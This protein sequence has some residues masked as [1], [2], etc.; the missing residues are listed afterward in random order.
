MGQCLPR[1]MRRPRSARQ[2]E[3]LAGDHKQKREQEPAGRRSLPLPTPIDCAQAPESLTPVG[4]WV[5]VEAQSVGSHHS[6]ILPASGLVWS[7][8]DDV[9]RKPLP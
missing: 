3:Y 9:K 8:W 7:R 6:P 2:T 1:Q 4:I 5:V